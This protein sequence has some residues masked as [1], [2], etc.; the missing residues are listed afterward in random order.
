MT[1]KQLLL[2]CIAV[3]VV[4]CIT[5][6]IA[7][8]YIQ[9]QRQIAKRKAILRQMLETAQ[10]QS[11]IFDIKILDTA[12]AHKGLAGLLQNISPTSLS[13]EVLNFVSRAL[14]GV[15]VEVYFRVTLPEGPAFYKFRAIIQDVNS[16]RHKSTLYISAPEDLAE[17]QKRIFIRIKPPKDKVSVIGVW[18]IDSSKP[19]PRN[20]S[21]INRP[22]LHYR[23]GMEREPVQVENVSATGMALSFPIEDLDIMPVDLDKGSQLLCLIIYHVGK[24]ERIVTFWCTCTVLHARVH[25]EPKSAL[26]L[27][28]EF[29]NWAVLEQGKSDIH[30]FHSTPSHGVSPI[31]QWVIHMD[32]EQRKL[33]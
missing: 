23:R 13:M 16:G 21:E 14:V 9:R 17:G 11:E 24:D 31:T 7:Q 19:M 18:E 4:L 25:E 6:I 26:V 5:A 15:T 32:L 3:L 20:T 29:T 33:L 1:G 28:M 27:G 2:V 22:L 8:A 12:A 30:W 10:E